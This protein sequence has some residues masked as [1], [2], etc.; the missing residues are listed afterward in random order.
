MQTSDFQCL[1]LLHKP[2]R[3]AYVWYI[4]KDTLFV[5]LLADS[6]IRDTALFDG[7]KSPL[8]N[9]KQIKFHALL[10]EKLRG[11]PEGLCRLF[12]SFLQ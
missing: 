11:D 4:A 12:R 5:V 1:P 7:M 2:Q 10:P 9:P 6:G 8:G 3:I